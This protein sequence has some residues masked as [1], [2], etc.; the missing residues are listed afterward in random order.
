MATLSR[1]FGTIPPV[2]CYPQQLNQVFLNLLVN[3]AQALES[4]GEI[5]VRTW[6]GEDNVFVSVKDTGTGMPPEVA[7]RIFEPFFT[8]KEVGKGTGLGL[9][10]S[11]DIVRKHGGEISVESEAGLGTTFTV[12]L[13]V[14]GPQGQDE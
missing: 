5:T 6:S 1:D 13:P 2:R 12:W 10:I 14:D 7:K 11:Y 3:A 9:S 4:Q 8:T